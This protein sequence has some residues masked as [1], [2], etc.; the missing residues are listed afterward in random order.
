MRL[1]ALAAAGAAPGVDRHRLAGDLERIAAKALEP[2]SAARYQSAAA[3]AEDVE[4]FLAGRPVEA[5]P[6]ALLYRAAKFARRH[7]LTVAASA[8][9]ALLLI[10]SGLVS[11]AQA[12]RA[13]REAEHAA[14]RLADVRELAGSFLFEIETGLRDLAGST[15]LRAQVVTTALRYLELLSAESA[16]DPALLE[17]LARGYV[18]VGEIQG[19]PYEPNLGEPEAALESAGRAL[20]QA[21]RLAELRPDERAGAERRAFALRLRGDV[22]GTFGR[23]TAARTTY[24]EA[25]AAARHAA[26]TDPA[27]LEL[28][29]LVSALLQR[30]ASTDQSLGHVEQAIRG[31]EQNLAESRELAAADPER[32]ERSVMVAQALLGQAL[33]TAGRGPEAL[34]AQRAALALA[35]RRLAAAPDRPETR[36]DWTAVADRTIDALLD[37]G[38]PPRRVPSPSGPSSCA[39]GSPPRIQP[40]SRRASTSQPPGTGSGCAPAKARIS[41]AP[42]LLSPSRWRSSSRSSRSARTTSLASKA[43]SR[44]TASSPRSSDSAATAPPPWPTSPPRVAI[45]SACAPSLPKERTSTNSRRSSTA[46]SLR[47]AGIGDRHVTPQGVPVPGLAGC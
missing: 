22:E 23:V 2:E 45:S 43:W 12:A 10:A 35:E 42:W 29:R 3:L 21:D 37:R 20:A 7:A 16:D 18:K 30:L 32:S 14:R 9:A 25:L 38:S 34:A 36:S 17:D 26:A 5:H 47:S 19:S 11:L 27:D 4:R 13:R 41:T 28:R 33:L 1:S 40:T 8:L 15:K 39:A 46:R 6:P 44:R 31:L 24:E